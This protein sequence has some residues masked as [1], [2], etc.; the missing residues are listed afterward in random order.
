MWRLNYYYY[1]SDT[2][3]KLLFLNRIFSYQ[4]LHSNLCQN[5]NRKLN[6]VLIRKKGV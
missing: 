2:E 5:F 1:A 4:S 6:R 3:I